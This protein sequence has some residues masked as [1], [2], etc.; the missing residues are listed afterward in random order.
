M[1]K[2]TFIFFL[3]VSILSLFV[4][5]EDYYKPELEVVPGLLVVESHVTNDPSQNF[6]RLFKT[7]DFYN[8]NTTE[9]VI[10]A[11][12]D[13]IEIGGQITRAVENSTGYFTFQK[14]LIPGKKYV[15]RV[16][17]QKDT[18]ESDQVTMPPIPQIDSLYTIHQVQQSYRTN[19][20]GVPE[21]VLTPGRKIAID[22]PITSALQYYRF[23]WK[24]VIEWVYYPP[25]V[26][27][28]P[29]PYF[30][31]ITKY[32]K[33]LFNIAGPK[34]FSVSTKV[35]NHPILSLAYDSELYLD[36]AKQIAMGWILIIDQYGISRDSYKFHDKLN[37]QFSADGSLFDPLLTQVYGNMRCKNDA[38]KI[39]LGFFD[40][41]SYRQYRYYLNLGTNENSKGI[42]RRLNRY[43]P[44][45]SAGY[46]RE[47]PPEFWE[48]YYQ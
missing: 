47:N 6:V 8:I 38:S 1:R 46:V 41:N 3:Q 44:I 33:G 28:P 11:K 17:Y 30:G 16:S 31:W 21:E 32:D 39:A 27:F 35:K 26:M 42:Q 20:Y 9:K 36:S 10:G 13:L 7:D 12:V 19:A 34:E 37:K 18:Y 40:L 24:A 15:L 23:S 22:A 4:S 45:P 5:C 29:P 43:L 48:N 2:L 14:T 25:A